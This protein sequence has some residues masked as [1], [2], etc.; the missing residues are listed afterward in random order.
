MIHTNTKRI[1]AISAATVLSLALLTSVALPVLSAH[2]QA[3]EIAARIAKNQEYLAQARTLFGQVLAEDAKLVQYEKEKESATSVQEKQEL[4]IKIQET[5]QTIDELHK[6]IDALEKLN[7]ALFRWDADVEQRLYAAEKAL[8]EKYIDSTSDKFVEDNPVEMVA[9]EP[10]TRDIHI[11]VNPDKVAPDGSNVP[12][13]SSIDGIPVRIEYGAPIELGCNPVDWTGECRP[14]IGGISV[15]EQDTAPDLNTLG[16]KAT[17]GG[18]VGFVI[19]GHTAQ[20]DNNIIVQ[21]HDDDTKVVGQVE[22]ICHTSCSGDF[23]WVDAS[24]GISVNDDLFITPTNS[25]WDIDSKRSDANQT[26]GTFIAKSGAASGYTSGQIY[27]NGVFIQADLSVSPGD[28]GSP[29][30]RSSGTAKAELFG[31]IFGEHPST[32]RAFYYAQDTIEAGI[33]AVASTS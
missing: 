4:E 22:E 2:A 27:T 7:Q 26:P 3:E 10:L 23:A 18:T 24:S 1:L 21:P 32:G 20:A 9:A 5:R 8:L 28:S 6:D 13:E 11:L 15:S 19:A 30:F 12:T 16:Y 33:G 25:F 17:V 31:M 14:V 29:V